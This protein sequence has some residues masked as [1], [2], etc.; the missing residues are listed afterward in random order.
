MRFHNEVDR[1]LFLLEVGKRIDEVDNNDDHTIFIKKRSLVVPMLKDFLKSRATARAW[2]RHPS[3]FLHGI[4]QFH[5][6]PEGRTLHR[7]LA[8]F[9]TTRLIMPKYNFTE[10]ESLSDKEKRDVHVI[11]KGELSYYHSVTDSA[12]IALV[13]DEIFL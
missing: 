12:V 2:T 10:S 7:K 11:L 9:I 3:K 6:S 8:R 5:H 1:M 13:L 4:R